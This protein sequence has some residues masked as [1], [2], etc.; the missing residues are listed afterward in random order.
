MQVAAA[1]TCPSLTI[2][3]LSFVSVTPLGQAPALFLPL[4]A[5]FFVSVLGSDACV[6]ASVLK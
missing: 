5:D 6:L 2:L 3:L 1:K 4:R